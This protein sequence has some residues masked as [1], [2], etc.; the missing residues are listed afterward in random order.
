MVERMGRKGLS[1]WTGRGVLVTGGS[2]GIGEALAR[3]L[4]REGARVALVARREAELERVADEIHR[5]GGQAHVVA[6]DLAEPKAAFEAGVEAERLLAP[7]GVEVLVNNAG[8]G[9][10]RRLLEWPLEDVERMTAVNYLAS[11]AITKAVLPGMVR[12]RSGWIVF[13]AS[14]AGKVATPLEAP[15]A[16][17]KAAVLAFAE[18]LSCEVEGQGVHV[19]SVCPGVIDT[20]FFGPDDLAQMPAVAR[21]GM[22]AVDGLVERVLQ[23]LCHRRWF[24]SKNSWKN[25]ISLSK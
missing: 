3:R 25:L 24:F 19:L 17:S 16:A 13:I 9:G 10:H 6:C 22:V 8:Y 14:V 12:R 4:G 11:V 5:A 1:D 18:A 20:P 15:Y 21:R 2:S 23:A 7:T